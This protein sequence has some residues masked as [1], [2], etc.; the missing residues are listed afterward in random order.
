M[1][2]GGNIL[3]IE[4]Y[5]HDAILLHACVGV[6]SSVKAD[7]VRPHVRAFIEGVREFAQGIE[8]GI[9]PWIHLNYADP[10]QAVLESY[11]L[12]NLAEIK[13]TAAKYDPEQVFQRLCPGG[14]KISFH[15]K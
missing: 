9:L 13:K 11:G 4:K 10:S 14:F 5:A 6:R 7:Q 15:G 1:A 2:A 8:D 12:E 3:G